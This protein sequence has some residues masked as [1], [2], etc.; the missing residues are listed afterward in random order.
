MTEKI[1][2]KENW[3]ED[4]IR[5]IVSHGWKICTNVEPICKMEKIL[6]TIDELTGLINAIALM[7]PTGISDN[8]G[9][10]CNEKVERQGICRRGK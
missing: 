8:E 5:A 4:Y 7:R 10:I 9:K 2:A 6:Y 1:L 3:P